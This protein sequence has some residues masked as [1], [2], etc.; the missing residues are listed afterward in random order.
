MKFITPEPEELSY[1]RADPLLTEQELDYWPE[2]AQALERAL[3]LRAGRAYWRTAHDHLMALELGDLGR[4]RPSTA[5][6]LG[7][8]ERFEPRPPEHEINQDLL[9]LVVWVSGLTDRLDPQITSKL[10]RVGVTKNKMTWPAGAVLRTPEERFADLPGFDHEPGYVEIEGLRMA[11]V[12]QGKGSPILMLHGQPTWSYLYRRMIPL[13]SHRGRVI[14]PD[15]I[16]LGRSDKPTLPHAYTYRSFTRW[17][18]AFIEKMELT[19]ITLIC[20][21]WGGGIGLRVLSQ[22]PER[23]GRLVAMNTA[24]PVGDCA[25]EPF[26][27]WRAWVA[28]MTNFRLAGFMNHV[29]T[30]KLSRQELA[31]YAAPFPTPAHQTAILKFPS[32]VPIRPDHPGAY[33]NRQA[34]EVLKNLDIP[35]LLIWGGQDEITRPCKVAMRAIFRQAPPVKMIRHAGHFIQEDAGEEVSAII[36]EWLG[37]E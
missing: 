36:D 5:T 12:E 19:D 13:L 32:L 35:T 6:V 15:Q 21:D 8:W 26:L 37:K 25:H 14:A 18:R 17:M 23:F 33:E 27:Q 16:G 22:M 9:D 10:A 30:R 29:L 2:L 24:L 4:G 28:R 3:G 11:Y 1:L 20:Q 31:G 7:F 34:L